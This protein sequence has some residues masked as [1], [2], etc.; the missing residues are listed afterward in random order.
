MAGCNHM[1]EIQESGAVSLNGSTTGGWGDQTL[2]ILFTIFIVALVFAVI[3]IAIAQTSTTLQSVQSQEDVLS[4]T[5]TNS[6][7]AIDIAGANTLKL[8]LSGSY[9]WISALLPLT[10][11]ITGNSISTYASFTAGVGMQLGAWTSNTNYPINTF[12]TSCVVNNN[13][14]YCVGDG[15]SRTNA[16][17]S[18]PITSNSLGAWVTNTAYPFPNWY[19]SCVANNNNI[20][21]IGGGDAGSNA[22][23]GA[24]L[25]GGSVGAWTT[26]TN[27]PLAIS[28]LSCVVNN[29]H[30]YCIGGFNGG[31]GIDTNAVY[32]APIT[33]NSIGAWT[34]NTVYPANT[35]GLSCTV[36]NNYIYCL[37]SSNSNSVAVYGAPITGNSIG[38]WTANTN[39]PT[40]LR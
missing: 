32:S 35:Q 7:N 38:A 37:G 14:I 30:V 34:V 17:Y 8:T 36:S 9:S 40:F 13:Q 22:V 20:Y 1:V 11:T 29:S 23:Y 27:Y 6:F 26:N 31:I 12:G 3:L 24:S 39:Y 5:S 2:N 33:S 19:E 18:A 21:C 25:N 4:A 10:L 15:G 28:L 16:V